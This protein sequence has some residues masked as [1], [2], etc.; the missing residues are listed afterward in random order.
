MEKIGLRRKPGRDF[1]HPM[2]DPEL[3]PHLVRHVFYGVT[4]AEWRAAQVGPAD[5]PSK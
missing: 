4:A 2:V 5:S 1:D 3:H